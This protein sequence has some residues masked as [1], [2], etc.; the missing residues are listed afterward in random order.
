MDSQLVHA[1]MLHVDGIATAVLPS[2]ERAQ[3]AA[4]EYL[5]GTSTL[6]I[7]TTSSELTTKSIGAASTREWNYDYRIQRW[8]EQAPRRVVW[9][10][11]FTITGGSR[12]RWACG[13]GAKRLVHMSTGRS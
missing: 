1:Y 2:L 13:Q 9:I 12:G 7:T 11:T 10:A 5:D 6:G 8:V 3:A 4:S